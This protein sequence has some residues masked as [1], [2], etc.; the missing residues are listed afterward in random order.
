MSASHTASGCSKTGALAQL[1]GSAVGPFLGL[2]LVI[3]LFWVA[4]A[5]FGRGNFATPKNARLVL[6]Q[7]TTVAMAALGMTIIIISGGIDLSAGTAMALSATVLAWCLKENYGAAAAVAAGIAT[8][9]LAG[10]INGVLI[11][12]LRVVPFI[13]TLGT[14]TI[15]LGLGKILGENT[16]VRPLAEQ[17]PWWLGEFLMPRPDPWWLILPP[18]VWL[19]IVLAVAVAVMLR[20]TV[21]GRHVVA[22]G[23]SEPTARLCGINVPLTRIAVYTLAGFFIGMAGMCQ[24]SR[25]SVGDPTSGLGK[26]LL[27]I[28]AVVIGGGSLGGGRGS[29]IGTLTGA[30]TMQVISSGCTALSLPNPIQEI[31]I[32]TIIVAAVTLDQFRQRHGAK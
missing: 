7:S 21:F 17:V 15:F 8:G 25:L 3:G 12:L 1:L 2:L 26:E 11:S 16:I 4:D 30:L 23:S 27:V 18:G 31:I 29:V 19:L 13:I 24:F 6:V 22:V 28:A 10:L 20:Y 5:V 32:G 14:M 9:C